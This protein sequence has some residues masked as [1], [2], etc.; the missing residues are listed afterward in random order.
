MDR[1]GKKKKQQKQQQKGHFGFDN[2]TGS[3]FQMFL[4]WRYIPISNPTKTQYAKF[5]VSMLFGSIYRRF[6]I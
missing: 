4:K 6:Y 5:Q 3:S 1:V 2:E